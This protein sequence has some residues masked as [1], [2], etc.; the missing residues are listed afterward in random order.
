MPFRVGGRFESVLAQPKHPVHP[1]LGGSARAAPVSRVFRRNL[2]LQNSES[3]TSLRDLHVKE[4]TTTVFRRRRHH[5]LFCP[6]ATRKEEP[7]M[8][9]KESSRRVRLGMCRST[10]VMKPPSRDA[11]DS[12]ATAPATPPPAGT[13]RMKQRPAHRSGFAIVRHCPGNHRALTRGPASIVVPGH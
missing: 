10:D 13:P 3:I 2:N 1:I 9:T 12:P 7:R 4:R 6:R 5:N 8:S 11:V